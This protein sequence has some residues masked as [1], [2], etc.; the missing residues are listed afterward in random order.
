MLT[1]NKKEGQTD[2]FRE[3]E[4]PQRGH[5]QQLKPK[6]VLMKPSRRR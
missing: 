3:S 4:S 6:Q 2:F 5:R 1:T